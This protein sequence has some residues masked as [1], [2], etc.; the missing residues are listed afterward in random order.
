M[1]NGR[2]LEERRVTERTGRKGCEGR[3][4][5]EANRLRIGGERG[6]G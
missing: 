3:W 4:R 1:R 5:T 2:D 6:G